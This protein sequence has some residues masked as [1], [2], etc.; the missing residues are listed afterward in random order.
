MLRKNA[1]IIT[2]M[3]TPS[4]SIDVL[5]TES[6]LAKKNFLALLKALFELQLQRQRACFL[7]RLVNKYSLI[8]IKIGFT[9]TMAKLFYYLTAH[10]E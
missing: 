10:R 5:L 6:K 4:N 2:R 7:N 1:L 9:G 3:K 8:K